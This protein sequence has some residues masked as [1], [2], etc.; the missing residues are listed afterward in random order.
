LQDEVI[1]WAAFFEEVR[2][3]ITLVDI[4][5]PKKILHLADEFNHFAIGLLYVGS[6]LERAGYEVE[7]VHVK[8][9]GDEEELRKLVERK[10]LFIG[11]SVLTGYFTEYAIARYTQ[12]VCKKRWRCILSI[13]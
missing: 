7:I 12:R 8:S 9:D 6:A 2:E 13:V 1:R 10:P 3:V 11:F 5:A 4:V